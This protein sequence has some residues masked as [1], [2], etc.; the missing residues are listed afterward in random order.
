[1]ENK[2]FLRKYFKYFFY[3]A[4]GL[5]VFLFFNYCSQTICLH[6]ESLTMPFDKDTVFF[7]NNFPVPFVANT[8]NQIFNSFLKSD[9]SW[10]IF[11]FVYIF[12]ERFVP[13]ALK[14]H[15]Q[16][17]IK[18]SSVFVLFPIFFIFLYN[19]S[20]CFVKYFSK[21]NFVLR[22][23]MLLFALCSSIVV[24]DNIWFGWV[25]YHDCWF[26]AYIFLPIFGIALYNLL[27]LFYIEQ[28]N[29]KI[30][31]AS[32]IIL[33]LCVAVGHEYY[34]FLFAVAFPIICFLHICVFKNKINKNIFFKYFFGFLFLL[35]I[36]LLNNVSTVYFEN[37]FD[38]HIRTSFDFYTFSTHLK[39]FLKSYFYYFFV[40]KYLY[41][42][43]ILLISF[44][45]IK[46]VPN[47]EK[48]KR[49]LIFSFSMFI[50]TVLFS[51]CLI[52][53]TPGYDGWF[54]FLTEHEGIRWLFD[55]TMLMI[56][57]SSVGFLFKNCVRSVRKKLR[58]ILFYFCLI[59][60]VLFFCKFIGSERYPFTFCYRKNL[61]IL[62]KFYI[63]NRKINDDFIF[64][65]Y[66]T[67]LVPEDAYIY[68]DYTYKLN[69]DNKEYELQN[70]CEA[71]DSFATVCRRNLIKKMY[72]KTHYK[73]NE[74]ELMFLD[75]E[76]LYKLR[77]MDFSK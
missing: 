57:L 62:E 74:E 35:S 54:L 8:L 43:L 48:M 77:D 44:L 67:S 75:F 59:F 55:L 4:T 23:L 27:E 69:P 31:T 12:I 5:I 47:K 13:F 70:V 36:F 20:N 42:F 56:I 51:L 6:S 29:I 25:F 68:L 71:K 58:R 61:Y 24:M 22:S 72:E 65:H 19:L 60:I 3:F 10:Y 14:M 9:H 64:Y 53:A 30:F 11:S 39:G 38:S 49:F 18:I 45:I 46:F 33:F 37:W 52:F 16:N 76:S 50:T 66:H 40:K 63:L 32:F 15:P 34:K 73:M 17:A 2:F 28:K 7:G 41:Y 1:M 21:K 26:L